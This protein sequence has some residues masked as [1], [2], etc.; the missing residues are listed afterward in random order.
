VDALYDKLLIV[1]DTDAAGNII[2]RERRT[3]VNHAMKTCRRAWNIALRRNPQ[4][5]P[6]L[7]PFAKMGLTSSKRETPTANYEELV[8]FRT[9]AREIGYGSLAT[10]ALIAWEWLQR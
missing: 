2:E 1:K 5:V 7:N 6:I 4:K 8:A 10:A 9:K 3:T